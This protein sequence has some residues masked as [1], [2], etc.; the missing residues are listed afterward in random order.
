MHFKCQ[1]WNIITP[2]SFC[3]TS[4]SSIRASANTE[5][6]KELYKTYYNNQ[7]ILDF[8]SEGETSIHREE[9]SDYKTGCHCIGKEF[10]SWYL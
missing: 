5:K 2:T 1:I 10:Q 9:G 6:E 7:N 3:F 8:I 4:Y